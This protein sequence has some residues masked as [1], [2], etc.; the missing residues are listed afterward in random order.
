[1]VSNYL[2]GRNEP[3]IHVQ[4]H[5]QKHSEFSERRTETR[6]RYKLLLQ[7]FYPLIKD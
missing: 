2:H 5:L 3:K 7:M 4:A 6:F 1:M